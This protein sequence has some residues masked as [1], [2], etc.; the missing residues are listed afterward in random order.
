LVRNYSKGGYVDRERQ[1]L[2]DAIDSV[3]GI[4]G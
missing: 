3:A 2:T 4:G 1:R